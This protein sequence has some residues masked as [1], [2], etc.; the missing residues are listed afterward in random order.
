MS[1]TATVE[2]NIVRIPANAHFPNGARVRIELLETPK[3]VSAMQ[4]W[5]RNAGGAAKPGVTTADIMRET[6][7]E[8]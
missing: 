6:R 1:I 3:S 5:L 8:E 2:D 7:G 4:E